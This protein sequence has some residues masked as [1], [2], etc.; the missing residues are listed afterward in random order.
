MKS[1]RVLLLAMSG[2]RVK[3]DELRQLGMT[4]PGFIERGQVIASLPSLSLLTLAAHTPEN[5]EAEY[6]EIDEL[7]DDAAAQ[8]ASAGYDIVAV[9]AFT[10]RILDAYEIADQLREAGVTV[11]LGGLHVSAL[12]DEAL[13]HADAVVV[14]EAE[15]L[16]PE[17]L[18]DFET[19]ALR[20]R[21]SSMDSPRRFDLAQA[22][23][24][25]YDM[26]D[27]DRY[28]RLT[29]QTSRGCP[30]DC[31]FCGAS[32]LIS[33]Y[34]IKPLAQ[35]RLELEAILN[36]WP[37]PFIE[38]A[39][40]NTFVSKKWAREL[41]RLFA[42]Y[43][44]RWFTETDLSV[45]DDDELL[46]LLALSGCAQVLIGLESVDPAALD[47]VDSRRWKQSQLADY[48]AKIR[49][50]QS[51]GITVNG[52]FIFGF[53]QDDARVFE[54]TREFVQASGLS[55]V[56]ITILDS[57]PRHGTLRQTPVRGTVIEAGLL[58]FLHAL[59]CDLSP[60]ANE[61]G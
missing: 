36:I 45:A 26:L 29:L 47:C 35:V 6:R 38:L 34:K 52:C 8:I 33:P 54:R 23:V 7:T 18:S 25:R 1:R 10:A 32:R 16:W 30:L 60:Q 27:V 5:W 3:N 17:L 50:I 51:Y 56:Q 49:K 44:I 2:V 11:V 4:L 43:R 41:A 13:A 19:A 48:T 9:S 61:H 37:E 55:E 22:Q 58:G 40:D 24:P 53:D 14:G 21:Y 12:P 42:E 57:F 15:L 20:P 39:D 59:R 28:N 46:E 31:E